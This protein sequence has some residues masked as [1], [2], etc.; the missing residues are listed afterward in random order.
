M[1]MREEIFEIWVPQEGVWSRWASP[2]LFGQLPESPDASDA[3]NFVSPLPAAWRPEF[4]AHQAVV[5]DLAGAIAVHVGLTFAQSGFRPVPIFNACDGPNPVIT[6]SE[7]MSALRFGA[8]A[9]CKIVIAD[10]APPVFLIDSR[11]MNEGVKVKPGIFDNRWKVFA[12]DF[13]SAEFFL[14]H[15]ITNCLLM[16]ANADIAEDLARVMLR[17]QSAGILLRRTLLNQ[18][19]FPEP[20]EEITI[21]AS[22]NY[23]SLW[24]RVAEQ[25]EFRQNVRGGYGYIVPEPSRG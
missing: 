5:I 25:E 8:E 18:K 9:L 2:V 22:P 19:E 15:G 12:Q 24:F 14:E 21:P 16:Q 6:Q 23:R 20:T 7:L 3:D 1:L 17:W 10:D 4:Y 13:P 11:R